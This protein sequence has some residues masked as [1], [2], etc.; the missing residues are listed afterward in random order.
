ML[1]VFRLNISEPAGVATSRKFISK[2][3]RLTFLVQIVKCHRA[4]NR[5]PRP[6]RRSRGS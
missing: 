6:P 3:A 2:L 4:M 5:I 1:E